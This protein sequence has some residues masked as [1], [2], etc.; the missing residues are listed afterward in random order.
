MCRLMYLLFLFSFFLVFIFPKGN[1]AHKDNPRMGREM[2]FLFAQTKLHEIN[3]ANPPYTVFNFA[4]EAASMYDMVEDKKKTLHKKA[5][6]RFR[7]DL[8][9]KKDRAS[10]LLSEVLRRSLHFFQHE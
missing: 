10:K 4:T 2:A 6:R 7:Q 1:V 5:M 9:E 3:V 8:G